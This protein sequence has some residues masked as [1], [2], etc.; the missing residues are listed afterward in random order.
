MFVFMD[1]STL[2]ASF[3]MQPSCCRLRS[4]CPLL[5]CYMC[6]CTYIE[7]ICWYAIICSGAYC[8]QL[9]IYLVLA[10]STCFLRHKSRGVYNFRQLKEKGNKYTYKTYGHPYNDTHAH[11]HTDNAWIAVHALTLSCAQ[12]SHVF[13]NIR[14]YGHEWVP[15]YVYVNR[16]SH[17]R[18]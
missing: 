6:I 4:P 2:A 11:I 12:L 8:V 10:Y 13:T 14:V 9:P 7:Y 16:H 5:A 15:F 3:A 17:A 1:W 18:T